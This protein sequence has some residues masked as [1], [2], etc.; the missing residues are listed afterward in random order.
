MILKD[1]QM[2]PLKVPVAVDVNGNIAM[3][4]D[5]PAGTKSLNITGVTSNIVY[6]GAQEVSTSIVGGIFGATYEQ[7]NIKQTVDRLTESGNAFGTYFELVVLDTGSP[8]V[9]PEEVTTKAQGKFCFPIPMIL[10]D[11]EVT[12]GDLFTIDTAEQFE[13]FAATID[14]NVIASADSLSISDDLGNFTDALYRK[15]VFWFIVGGE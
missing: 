15:C 9:V 4:G 6:E 8:I 13:R 1:E 3:Q 5:T 10:T 2:S 12:I 11:S 7:G 14:G